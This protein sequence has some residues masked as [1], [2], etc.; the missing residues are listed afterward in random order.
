VEFIFHTKDLPYPHHC[1]SGVVGG[2]KVGTQRWSIRYRKIKF[3]LL[4]LFTFILKKIRKPAFRRL[5]QDSSKLKAN[6]DYVVI[7]CLL[8]KSKNVLFL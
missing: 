2:P 6:L 7:C 4:T 8:K 1:N 3:G 5:M